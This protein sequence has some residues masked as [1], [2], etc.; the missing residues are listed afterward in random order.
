MNDKVLEDRCSDADAPRVI[1][2]IKGSSVLNDQCARKTKDEI[3]KGHVE[4]LVN[5]NDAKLFLK[6]IK[7]YDQL[8]AE[9]KAKLE[10]PYIQTTSLINEM[11]NLSNV[12]VDNVIKLKEPRSGRKDRY[13]AFSYGIYFT[14]VLTQMFLDNEDNNWGDS[15]DEE[16]YY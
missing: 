2:S 13:S 4:F 14:G 5:H 8:S 1:Y 15:D 3:M 7:G 9:D 10:F 16:V 12:G 11:V 6:D